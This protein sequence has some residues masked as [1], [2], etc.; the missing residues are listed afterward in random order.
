MSQMLPGGGTRLIG[1]HASM[2]LLAQRLSMILGSPVVDLTNT[3]GSYDFVLEASKE[4]MR[5]GDTRIVEGEPASVNP[6]A[7][8]GTSVFSSIQTLG[9]KL[10]RQKVPLD[11]IVVDQAEKVPVEN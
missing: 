5:D 8:P 3:P 10:K 2:D 4:D 1:E 9:L 11:V 6:E 7:S